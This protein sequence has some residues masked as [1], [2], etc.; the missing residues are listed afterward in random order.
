[1]IYLISLKY[2]DIKKDKIFNTKNF[3]YTLLIKTQNSI[4]SDFINKKKFFI[5]K[6]LK[7]KKKQCYKIQDHRIVRV[8]NPEIILLNYLKFNSSFISIKTFKTDNIVY[9]NLKLITKKV[10][11]TYKL[12]FHS[13]KAYID[14]IKE[15]KRDFFSEKAFNITFENM[16]YCLNSRKFLEIDFY[17][18]DDQGTIEYDDAIGFC[19]LVNGY[20]LFVAIADLSEIWNIHLDR[21]VLEFPQSLYTYNSKFYMLPKNLIDLFSLKKGNNRPALVFNFKINSNN[22]IQSYQFEPYIIRVKSN[23]SYEKGE[24]FFKE[25]QFLYFL[26]NN[27]LERRLNNGAI[28]LDNTNGMRFVIQELMIMVNYIVAKI[29]YKNNIPFISRTIKIPPQIKKYCGKRYSLNHTEFK[30]LK[31]KILNSIDFARYS[32]NDHEH[33]FLGLDKYTHITSPIR[34]YIDVINQKQLI[35]YL[36]NFDSFFNSYELKQILDIVN[37]IIQKYNTLVRKYNRKQK[38]IRFTYKLI[39]SN[40]KNKLF[41]YYICN[42]NLHIILDEIGEEINAGLLSMFENKIIDEYRIS[43]NVNEM[44]S[45]LKKEIE[46]V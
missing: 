46:I 10:N 20:D 2:F 7:L 24:Q 1:M 22:E 31:Y 16:K 13:M 41:L 15:I 6:L 4:L 23:F 42:G 9:K 26:S 44:V 5:R 36:Y 25:N 17:T 43:L 19:K 38:L 37:P 29:L 40:R 11:L 45:L 14:L 12:F 33:E 8:K 32:I 27:L 34:R 3:P 35:S 28:Y 21:Y 18:F 39:N 30:I